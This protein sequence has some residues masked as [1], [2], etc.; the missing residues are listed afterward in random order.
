MSNVMS[1]EELDAALD[2]TVHEAL[3][4]EAPAPPPPPPAPSPV[5][6]A[7]DAPEAPAAQD[8]QEPVADTKGDVQEKP[9][10]GSTEGGTEEAF[11]LEKL[12]ET[13]ENERATSQ[14]QINTLRQQL[15]ATQEQL[16]KLTA[17]QQSVAEQPPPVLSFVKDED[18]LQQM[19]ESPEAANQV[20]TAIAE[21]MVQ[22]VLPH[23]QDIAKSQA[24]DVTARQQ[25]YNE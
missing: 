12:K 8:N 3:L 18:Q 22:R 17:T 13:Y 11:T 6:D 2:E 20:F 4:D 15:L 9:T 14:Q 25:I 10:E 7:P 16:A 1:D 23:V 5:P 21:S 19:M 24:Y